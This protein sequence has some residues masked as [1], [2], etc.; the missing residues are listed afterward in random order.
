MI[1]L[2]K[3]K[4]IRVKNKNTEKGGVKYAGKEG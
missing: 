2:E 4:N 3:G 1:M